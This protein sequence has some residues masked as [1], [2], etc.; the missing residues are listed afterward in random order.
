MIYVKDGGK[1]ELTNSTLAFSEWYG[2]LIEGAE[3]PNIVDNHF[4]DCG[5]EAIRIIDD[6]DGNAAAP[7]I[8]NNV[9]DNSVLGAIV[10]GG[11]YLTGERTIT[12]NSGSGNG[13][14]SIYV[15]AAFT[16]NTTL[17]ADNE[18]S[19]H[20][21]GDA[22]IPTGQTLVIDP[23]AVVKYAGGELDVSGTLIANGTDGNEVVFTSL[24]DD[25]YGGDTNAD[26]EAT[27]PAAGQWEGI[28]VSGSGNATLDHTI[29]RYGGH[30]GSLSWDTLIYVKDGGKLE[31][32]N[33]T[34]AFSEWYGVLIEG[35]E[36]PNIVDNHFHDCGREAIRIIDDA[37]GNA[38]APVIRNNVIDNSVL[39]AIVIGGQYLT[40]ERTITGNSGS[41]NG[42]NSIYV[43][44]AF[45]GNTTLSADNELSWHFAGDADIPTGQ[46]LVIDPGAVVK[47][48][49]GELDVSGTLIANGTD[50]NEVVFTSLSDDAYGGDT[51]ADGEATVPAA[52]QWEGIY[53]SGSGNATLDHTIIRYGGHYG[54]L[55]WDTLIYV[56]DGGKLELTNS[57]LAFSEWYGVLIEG[58]ETPN[59][60]DNHFH[61]CGREAIRIIDD[62]DGECC[63][64][65]NSE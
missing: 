27:V 30:Y 33:S 25:A 54:S 56:K 38:A 6:A 16:G 24:S 12:G 26:G 45:T 28:Y 49:G 9:I 5:R 19:W 46:T 52:G 55:S 50:G 36:T 31:L 1:L 18:L 48:A 35:A 58:A 3:T 39:G 65:R 42:T 11:Q 47:Y 57:T 63:C 59:I 7:V 37:D 15:S 8:R 23:G 61:D 60:V 13:T 53:V 34:L 44:A 40:G 29:I 4:H 10:I 21:A 22:D 17:S 43:S 14:N 20:F 32:T 2:V 51:N 62:A 64:P 41:G